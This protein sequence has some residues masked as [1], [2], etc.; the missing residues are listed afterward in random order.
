MNFEDNKK[1]PLKVQKLQGTATDQSSQR[2]NAKS[3]LR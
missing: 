2:A 1:N 3:L